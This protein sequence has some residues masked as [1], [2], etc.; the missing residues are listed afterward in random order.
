MVSGIVQD[1][2]A[3]ETRFNSSTERRR[4]PRSVSDSIELG[5]SVGVEL[6]DG[7][8]EFD[9]APDSGG[10]LCRLAGMAEMPS[11]HE[12]VGFNVL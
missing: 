1:I 10:L 7:I 5:E 2:L 12:V 8:S 3:P 4:T 6:L 11:V 9:Q